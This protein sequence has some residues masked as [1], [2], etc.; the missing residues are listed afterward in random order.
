MNGSLSC[1]TTNHISWL[2]ERL[3]AEGV[4]TS[5]QDL[6]A[7]GRDETEDL[8]FPPDVVLRPRNTTEVST[9]LEFAHHERIPVT[10]RGAGTGL[11]GGALPVCGGLVLSLERLDKIR[12][13]NPRDMVAVVDSGVV[14]G[15]LISAAAEQ[16]LLYGPNPSSLDS[17]SIGGNIAENAAGP[18]SLKYGTTKEQVLGLEVVLCDGTVVTT[19]G[20]NR[21]DVAGYDLTRL[22]VGSEGTLGIV[23]AATLRLVPAPGYR[24][25]VLASFDDLE[26]A[27]TAVEILCREVPAIAACEIV[28][29]PAIRAVAAVTELPGSLEGAQAVL[30]LEI[31]AE[32]SEATLAAAERVQEKI[33]PLTALDLQVALD[34]KDEERLWKVRRGIGHAVK[35]RS[36]YKEVDTVVPRS[37]LASL[38]RAAQEVATAH[39]IEA[40]CYGHAGDGNLHVNLLRGDLSADRWGQSRDSAERE[41]FARARALGGSITG[42]HGVGWTQREAFARHESAVLLDRM[43][44]IKRL[45]DPRGILNPGKIFLESGNCDE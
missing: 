4:S 31:H 13:L 24:T 1:V 36:I 16:G 39:G 45:F 43:R 11:S 33:Q 15:H 10:A 20:K 42:E 44:A 26:R 38:V 8:H 29:G 17:C 19:G 23:T 30:L 12:E 34:R 7:Y 28:D 22:L 35:A 32:N 41:L 25:S 27:A 3:G 14:T 5:E 2:R 21:K 37:Q 40:I 9:I 18:L 6:D